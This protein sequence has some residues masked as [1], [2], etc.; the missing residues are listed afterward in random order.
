MRDACWG[1]PHREK[2]KVPEE[3]NGHEGRERLASRP[4]GFADAWFRLQSTASDFV[5]SALTTR[6]FE[7]WD[8]CTLWKNWPCAMIPLA[9]EPVSHSLSSVLEIMR[10]VN[11]KMVPRISRT[12]GGRGKPWCSAEDKTLKTACCGLPCLSCVSC[13]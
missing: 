2:C 10:E 13:R 12:L 11:G 8:N 7:D 3:N 5:V 4:P 6:I 1:D 9:L